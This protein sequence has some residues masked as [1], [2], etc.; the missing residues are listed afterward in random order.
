MPDL[1]RTMIEIEADK[2]TENER[3]E[4]EAGPDRGPKESHVEPG[5]E[6]QWVQAPC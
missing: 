1:G 2:G 5:Q 6:D 3:R 4:E